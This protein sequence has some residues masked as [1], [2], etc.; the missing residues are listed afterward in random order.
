MLGRWLTRKSY[1]RITSKNQ[2]ILI[3]IH[4]SDKQSAIAKMTSWINLTSVVFIALI[5]RLFRIGRRSTCKAS[6]RLETP[7]VTTLDSVARFLWTPKTYDRVFK[8]ARADLVDAWEQAHITGETR[9]AWYIKHVL[10]RWIM[11]SHMASQTPSSLIK[12]LL[13]FFEVSK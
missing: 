1:W 13:K 8:P 7:P 2:L 3:G 5:V 6:A 9:R 11:L 4:S 10:S 12:L